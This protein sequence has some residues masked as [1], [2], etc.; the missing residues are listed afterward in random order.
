MELNE[1]RHKRRSADI[2]LTA[3]EDECAWRW[4]S[5]VHYAFLRDRANELLQLGEVSVAARNLLASKAFERYQSSLQHRAEA[6]TRFCWHFEYQVW[7]SE[8]VIATTGSEGHLFEVGTYKLLGC[9]KHHHGPE[10]E[11]VVTR[12]LDFVECRIGWLRGL[13][14]ERPSGPPWRL[15]LKQQSP[16]PKHWAADTPCY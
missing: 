1:L 16:A 10:A 6:E 15:A 3:F 9:I 13:D 14:I 2:W 8:K 12:W 11:L 5:E 4:T 7:E